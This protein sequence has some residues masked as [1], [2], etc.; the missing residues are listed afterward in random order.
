MFELNDPIETTTTD[1]YPFESLSRLAPTTPM[2]ANRDYVYSTLVA[3][4]PRAP[5]T[6]RIQPR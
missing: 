1:S 2:R 5:I 4:A 3:M 6:Q